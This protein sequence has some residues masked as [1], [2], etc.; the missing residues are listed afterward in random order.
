ML[1]N[2]PSNAGK[3]SLIP[4]WGT[5]IPPTT[6]CGQKA[7][8]AASLTV[9]DDAPVRQLLHEFNRCLSVRR[10]LVFDQPVNQLFRDKAVRVGL[11]MMPPVFNHLL[12]VQPEPGERSWQS[13]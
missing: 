2:L 6:A 4:A 5:E 8:V 13:L 12:L 7:L 11:E 10:L 3:A 9:V 1:K